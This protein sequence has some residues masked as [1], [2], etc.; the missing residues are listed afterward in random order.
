MK[1]QRSPPRSVDPFEPLPFKV[2]TPSDVA[3]AACQKIATLPGVAA[4]E[5]ELAST[6]NSAFS[7]ET[8]MWMSPP[9]GREQLPR[10]TAVLLAD[11]LRKEDLR[12]GDD[13]ADWYQNPWPVLHPCAWQVECK[14]DA[15]FE[16]ASSTPTST[17]TSLSYLAGQLEAPRWSTRAS[18]ARQGSSFED[19]HHV[20][21]RVVA[22]SLHQVPRMLRGLLA[23]PSFQHEHVSVPALAWARTYETVH[24]MCSVGGS[25]EVI[26]TITAEDVMAARLLPL[27]AVQPGA[28]SKPI[29]RVAG[30]AA[31][32]RK[33][34]AREVTDLAA[35]LLR[36]T[37]PTVLGSE[38]KDACTAARAVVAG[39]RHPGDESLAFAAATLPSFLE[40]FSNIVFNAIGV[41][42]P[43]LAALRWY[44]SGVHKIMS[45]MDKWC[46]RYIDEYRQDASKAGPDASS[47]ETLRL[48]DL[49][50]SLRPTQAGARA[51]KQH[52]LAAVLAA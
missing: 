11:L 3:L 19:P 27:F 24:H 23:A 20:G 35:Q 51:P 36:A 42:G 30:L 44:A 12:R 7:R 43:A 13:A 31:E 21:Q 39:F 32:V 37:G 5:A 48:A 52:A 17:I 9:Q 1:R 25:L 33:T 46:R 10:E 8:P 16:K 50:G 28:V 49:A 38:S 15:A 40:G 29:A 6:W 14:V 45:S 41:R 34:V 4:I 26:P 18:G 2:E 22:S 47:A